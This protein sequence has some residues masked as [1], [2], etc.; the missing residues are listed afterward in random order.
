M[1]KP[2]HSRAALAVALSKLKGFSDPKVSL[3]QYTT[4]PDVAADML[5]NAL[6]QG[7]I[8]GKKVAD[9][10]AGTGFLGIGA[11]ILGAA[12][13]I[14][15]ESEGSALDITRVNLAWAQEAYGFAGSARF[16]EADVKQFQEEVDTVVENPPFG[17]KVVHADKT[18]LETALHIAKKAYSLHK[19]TSESFVQAI[20]RDHGAQ[21][22]LAGKYLYPLP[23]TMAHHTQKRAF[24]EVSLFVFS[25]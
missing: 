9:L 22:V 16:I 23:A 20:A 18:F 11:L 3:E 13:V 5:W 21:V 14:F 10:G 24:I 1:A 2:V 17:T 7:D 19:T 15:V 4:E 25:K 8:D 6:M 12:E